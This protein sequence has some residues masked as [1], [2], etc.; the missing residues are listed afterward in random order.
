MTEDEARM[1]VGTE[2]DPQKL[3]MQVEGLKDVLKLAVSGLP[4]QSL[5]NLRDALEEV[6]A[7]SVEI[8]GMAEALEIVKEHSAEVPHVQ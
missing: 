5:K 1:L 7:G 2:L 6:C 4:P 3:Y 8:P